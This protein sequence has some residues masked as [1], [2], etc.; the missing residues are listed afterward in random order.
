[1][2]VNICLIIVQDYYVF[3]VTAAF[4]IHV[5]YEWSGRTQGRTD[6]FSPNHISDPNKVWIQV[7]F[8]TAFGFS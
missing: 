2:N 3:T 7:A 1:M 8:L 4:N 6:T 5:C